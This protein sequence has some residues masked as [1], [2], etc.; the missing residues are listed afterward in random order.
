MAVS[1]DIEQVVE[2]PNGVIV[3]LDPIRKQDW[4]RGVI[5]TV[6]GTPVQ[7]IRHID[8]QTKRQRRKDGKYGWEIRGSN[9]NLYYNGY[10]GTYRPGTRILT[11][12]DPTKNPN[13]RS[14]TR[15]A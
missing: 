1:K 6:D 8:Q 2:F 14:R 15:R 5:Q 3:E 4:R 13:F 10:Q 9:I 7:V 12:G 11:D